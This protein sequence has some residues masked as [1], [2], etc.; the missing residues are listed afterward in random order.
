MELGKLGMATEFG[1]FPPYPSRI[2]YP[3]WQMCGKQERIQEKK[4]K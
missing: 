4:T 3:S 2:G 1:H